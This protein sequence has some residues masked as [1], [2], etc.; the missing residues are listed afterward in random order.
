M[1]EEQEY[2]VDGEILVEGRGEVVPLYEWEADGAL[3]AQVEW[4]EKQDA[5]KPYPHH[6]RP[7]QH[8]GPARHPS[9]GENQRRQDH[10]SH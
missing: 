9:H 10:Y 8:K 1:A 2:A 5:E 3:V 7:R 4:G 6:P